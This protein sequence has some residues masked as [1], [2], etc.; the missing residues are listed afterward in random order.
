MSVLQAEKLA[1]DGGALRNCR[2]AVPLESLERHLATDVLAS[3]LFG[4]MSSRNS[5]RYHLCFVQTT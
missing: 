3:G 1:M 5:I 4:S 2:P